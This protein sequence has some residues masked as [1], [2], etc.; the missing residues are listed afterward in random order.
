MCSV[1]REVEVNEG[2]SQKVERMQVLGVCF[3]RELRGSR[4]FQKVSE[5]RKSCP[6][7]GCVNCPAPGKF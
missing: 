1:G 3:D 5:W 7:G 6:C 4:S 2:R